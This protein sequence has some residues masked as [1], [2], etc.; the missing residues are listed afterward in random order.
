MPGTLLQAGDEEADAGSHAICRTA[1][2]ALSSGHSVQAFMK[3][4]I[5]QYFTRRF[6]VPCQE[7]HKQ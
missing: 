7:Q 4:R 3:E 2:A 5:Y 1:H 6:G